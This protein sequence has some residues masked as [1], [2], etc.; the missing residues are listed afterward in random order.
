MNNRITLVLS[1]LVLIV[2][3]TANLH[4]RDVID[5][6][7]RRVSV[8]EDITRIASPY[9]VATEMLL[10]LGAAGKI[11][12]VS[13]M[14]T[15]V[16][17][18]FYPGL[19]QAGIADRH[20]SLEEILSLQPD[21][22]FTSPGPVVEGL[23]KAGI[24]VFCLEVETPDAMLAGL[25]MIADVLGQQEHAG[26]IAAYYRDKLAYIAAKTSGISPKK[27]VYLIGARTLTTIG[28]D[29]YQDH[30]ITYAGGINV[31]HELKGGWVGVSREHLVSWDPDVMVMVPY[32]QGVSSTEILNDKALSTLTALRN[33]QIHTFPS[34]I[35]AWDLPSPESILGI[36]WLANTLYPDQLR[37]DMSE[38]ARHFYITFYGTYPQEI[39]LGGGVK[40]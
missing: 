13:T 30:I 15:R 4:A 22:V 10:V 14:P 25:S 9:R 29:F 20:S 21:V 16:T 12:G 7:G 36:M 3:Q 23:E 26:K 31:S 34:Y 1:V 33:R 35:D 11:V 27:K 32:F 24:A 8:P 19:A 18:I 39:S 2:L 40:P 28:G 5:M 17:R 37:F 38:E 6:T